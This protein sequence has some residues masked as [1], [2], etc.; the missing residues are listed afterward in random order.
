MKQH[1][2]RR[3]LKLLQSLFLSGLFALLPLAFTVFVFT[4]ILKTAHRWC[5]PLLEL[6]PAYLQNI[7]LIEL[8]IVA[9]FLI[10]I[11]IVLKFFLLKWLVEQVEELLRKVPL[12][13][14]VY[15]GTKQLI[16]ALSPQEGTHFQKVVLLEFPRKGIYSLGFLTCL[17]T[18]LILTHVE[19]EG[20]STAATA[21]YNIFIP[22]TPNPTGGAFVIVPAHECI[23]TDL[24][25][26]DAMAIII[27]GGIIQPDMIGCT[28]T[29]K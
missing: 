2:F 16:N 22:H 7:P 20:E 3:L 26:Q 9:L 24:S 23:M 15:F 29:K 14:Q 1:L 28:I 19:K 21:Y 11:G 13:K 6:L 17:N 8:F 12:V 18:S 4:F 10:G 27:S 5:M 25:R